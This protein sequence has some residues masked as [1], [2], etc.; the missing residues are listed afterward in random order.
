LCQKWPPAL[1]FSEPLRAAIRKIL[2][3]RWQNFAGKVSQI[4]DAG[5]VNARTQDC[6]PIQR[7]RTARNYMPTETLSAPPVEIE[8]EVELR[9]S[10][11]DTNGTG[12]NPPDDPGDEPH[13]V[14]ELDPRRSPTP[15]GAY[16]M[17]TFFGIAW[18]MFLFAALTLVLESRWVHSKD[19]ISI[20]L[21]DILYLSTA[22]L[23]ASSVAIEFGRSAL[24]TKDT[25]KC[26][27]WIL[28]AAAT[29][30]AFIA[31]QTFG[32]AESSWRG[33]NP[34][35]NPGAFFF[36][37]LT[38]THAVHV[39]AG[40]IALVCAGLVTIRKTVTL[41]QLAAL[42]TIAVYWHFVGGLWL[43]LFALLLFTIQS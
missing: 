5:A 27:R 1:L 22:I 11:R 23:L 3:L 21:P 15:A 28:G 41:N 19:W 35:D 10:D 26:A 18:T 31:C 4:L 25:E 14:S 9:L 20:P 8:I 29:A 12:G 38:G 30:C 42:D 33:V 6:R 40:M 7:L 17:F 34:N 32:L 37:L 24:R 16:R 36:Y 43:Y 39:I 2:V 13:E